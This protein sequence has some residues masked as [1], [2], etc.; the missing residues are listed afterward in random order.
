MLSSELNEIKIKNFLEDPSE[1]A[2]KN[3]VNQIDSTTKQTNSYFPPEGVL[4]FS[5]ILDK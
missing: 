2:N 4:D 3:F 5:E 1:E